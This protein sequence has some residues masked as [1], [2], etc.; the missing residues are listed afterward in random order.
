[1]TTAVDLPLYFASKQGQRTL[2]RL[3]R[4][5][6]YLLLILL[7]I[8]FIFPFWWMI[9]SAFK[10][11]TAIFEFPPR[12]LPEVWHPENFGDVFTYQP[13]AQHYFNS[14]YIAVL[15]TA[16]TLIVASLSGYAFARIR[17][18]GRTVLFVIL[19]SS[20]MMPSE[21]TI[22]PNFFFMK[23]LSLINTHVPLILIP[24]F[25]APS[26]LGAFMMRQ[27]FVSIPQEIEEA[28]MLDGAGR[29]GIFWRIVLPLAR[30]ALGG[31]AILVFLASWNNFLEPLVYLD[32][33]NLFTLP[34]SLRNFND[35][36]GTP[37]WHLQLAATTLSVVPVLIIYVIAQRQII[38]TFAASGVKG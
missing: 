17:F 37:L 7:A 2:A 6:T 24:I 4:A 38:D 18:P 8:P 19:L 1:M 35:V 3:Q 5:S 27:F 32:D 34:L 30:P 25:G 11:Q 10:D 22:I 15:V 16:G 26:V 12:L 36:Y 33:L 20:L 9:T 23:E 29:L 13:F 31:L 28:A 14:L 21:V